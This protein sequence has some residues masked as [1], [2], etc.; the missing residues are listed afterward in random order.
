[1]INSV[2]TIAN[3]DLRLAANQKAWPT[4]S[5]V[6]NVLSGLFADM[7]VSTHRAHPFDPEKQHGFIDS[8]YRGMEVFRSIN[9]NRALVVINTTWQYSHHILH[10]LLSHRAPILTIANFSG[11]WPG[12]V[13]MLNLNASMRKA[14][15]PYSTLWSVNFDDEFFIDGLKTWLKD[16]RLIPDQRHV[17][18]PEQSE[19][20]STEWNLG[21]AIG[22]A[23]RTEKTIVGVFDEGCMGMY[24]AIIPDAILN[25][26]GVFKERLSQ[27][28][29][30]Y[31]T[32][33]VT[34]DE[35]DAI[36]HWLENRGMT[37]HTGTDPDTDLTD[38]Q[39]RTQLKMYIAA[40]RLADEFGCEA[41]GIQYQ[42]GLKDVLPASDLAEGLLNSTDRPPI[43]SAG[44]AREIRSGRA[45]PHF[46][47]VD[48]CAGVDALVTH[49]VW[50]ELSFDP[51]T[52]L[53]DVRWGDMWGDEFV[54]VFEISGAAPVEHLR[55]GYRGAS[56]M[57]QPPMY[58]RLGGGTLRGVCKPGHIVWSRVF[59][60]D[61]RLC[62]D[63]GTGR[64]LDLPD[65]ETNRRWHA[66]NYEWPIMHAVLDGVSRDQMMG[67]H[68]SNH[69][70][71][72]YA[73]DAAAARNAM[74]AKS[75]ALSAMGVEIYFCGVPSPGS[76]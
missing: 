4:Q 23:I 51:A 63:I 62:C 13:G 29:L 36:R 54:W 75:G 17:R 11:Q 26:T 55:D 38:D 3:A 28:A 8:Q 27:S 43:L 48:E 46:N 6:E 49:R 66:T 72:A 58:F 16:S 25:R 45:I 9:P 41:I 40:G 65:E 18:S 2:T 68:P 10:G 33:L 47:E 15:I 56:S 76:L 32:Q 24:N 70:Q 44:S 52:T 39:I 7:G 53:H 21:G 1:M 73:P 74:L 57:R 19:T 37:F 59:L 60:E 34:D 50:S 12:L 5:R 31:A 30:A 14:G 22:R 42:Q 71:V 64:V 67:R 69:V 61:D 20:G 35:A